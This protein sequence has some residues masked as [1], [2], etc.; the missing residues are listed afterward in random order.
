MLSRMPRE[1]EPSI[2][3]ALGI[4]LQGMMGS[5]TV[6]SENVR[7]VAGHAGLQPDI[8]VTEPGHA[9]VFNSPRC[10]A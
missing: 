10:I 9:E 3:N 5:A 4:L 1:T 2:N 8:I 7:A 6:R